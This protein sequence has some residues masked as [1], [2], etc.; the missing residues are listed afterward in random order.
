MILESWKKKIDEKPTAS[1]KEQQS[2][3]LPHSSLPHSTNNLHGSI[4]PTK[5]SFNDVRLL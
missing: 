5:S 2:K 4:S 1:T 3:I